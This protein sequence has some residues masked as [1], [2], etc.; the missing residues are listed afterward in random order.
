[1]DEDALH[2]TKIVHEDFVRQ[3]FPVSDDHVGR[4][5]FDTSLQTVK[6]YVLDFYEEYTFECTYLLLT[7][8]DWT[9]FYNQIWREFYFHST[10]HKHECS[11]PIKT[12]T[13]CNKTKHSTT[14]VDR[15]AH[16][17]AN[18]KPQAHT[19]R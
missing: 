7:S 5:V 10:R 4:F 3:D 18:S 13:V 1:M 19:T 6:L 11:Q 8:I 15:R 17:R 9:Y 12:R 16:G 14:H 2:L